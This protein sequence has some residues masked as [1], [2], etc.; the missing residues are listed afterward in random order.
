MKLNTMNKQANV[1]ERYQSI[2]LLTKTISLSASNLIK[3]LIV[4]NALMN[5]SSNTICKYL[6]GTFQK[7]K[8]DKKSLGNLRKVSFGIAQ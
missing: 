5:K 6:R 3:F 2:V 4:I 1:N 7:S 8:E